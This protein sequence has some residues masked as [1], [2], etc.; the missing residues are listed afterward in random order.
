VIVEARTTEDRLGVDAATVEKTVEVFVLP[1][2]VKDRMDELLALS[3][4]FERLRT[5]IEHLGEAVHRSATRALA[6]GKTSRPERPLD[7]YEPEKRVGG[8]YETIQ[9][10][11]DRRPTATPPNGKLPKGA[12]EMLRQL[13][14]MKRPLTTAEVAALSGIPPKGSTFRTYRS[15]LRTRGLI[16]SRRDDLLEISDTGFAL[17]GPVAGPKSSQEL[18]DYWSRRL[19]A[20]AREM[21][22]A[23]M[24]MYPDRVTKGQLGERTKIEATKSTFRTYLSL[25]KRR[26]LVAVVGI[27]V[28]ASPALFGGGR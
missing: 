9:I 17:V 2:D 10:G 5:G 28:S 22:D 3:E 16:E 14:A 6:S 7:L 8:K 4:E 13:V 19:P 26:G 12:R 23:L 25:L 21:L 15:L 1:P 24:K 27:W 18:F 11:V 20:G